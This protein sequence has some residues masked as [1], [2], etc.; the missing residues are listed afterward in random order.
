[1]T[2]CGVRAAYVLQTPWKISIAELWV[3]RVVLDE[4][5][6]VDEDEEE[7]L[8][9][10]VEGVGVVEEEVE[11]E[12]VERE[13]VDC[14]GVGFVWGGGGAGAAEVGGLVAGEEGWRLGAIFFGCLA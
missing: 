3:E 14:G 7:S 13:G 5:E 8:E 11:E 6:E 9:A 2:R 12:R 4:G 10:R 1:M